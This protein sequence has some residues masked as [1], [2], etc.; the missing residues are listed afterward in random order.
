M[1]SH[2]KQPCGFRCLRDERGAAGL[3][4]VVIFTALV[5]IIGASITFVSLD[6]LETG[7]GL[8]R[9]SEAVLAAESCVQEGI[10]RISRNANY[11]GGNLEVGRASCA[12]TVS[13]TPCGICTV[14]ASATIGRFVRT[15]EA[16]VNRGAD[17]Q[18]TSWQ[19]VE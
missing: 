16:V 17:M 18:I 11:A 9:G 10:L 7:S 13:G 6:T 19:E 2:F 12:I 4:A 8:R 14:R 1:Q 15:I 5:V 3:L